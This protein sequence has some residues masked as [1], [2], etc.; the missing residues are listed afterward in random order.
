[1]HAVLQSLGVRANATS[2]PL[3]VA[4]PIATGGVERSLPVSLVGDLAMVG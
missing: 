1:M 3:R 2:A 4:L